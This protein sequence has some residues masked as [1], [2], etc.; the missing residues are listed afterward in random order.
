MAIKI[1]LFQG[2]EEQI[3]EDNSKPFNSAVH[4]CPLCSQTFK[5]TLLLES[6]FC[7]QH[8]V[9]QNVGIVVRLH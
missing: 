5:D 6:H 3:S 2:L 9:L 4:A 1:F 7:A 8:D